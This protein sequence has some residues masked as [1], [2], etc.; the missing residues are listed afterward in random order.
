MTTRC[1]RPGRPVRLPTAQ[2]A[3]VR[4]RMHTTAPGPQTCRGG[5]CHLSSHGEVVLCERHAAALLVGGWA[6]MTATITTLPPHLLVID[7]DLQHLAALQAAG[8]D[9]DETERELWSWSIRCPYSGRD[10]S[11]PCVCWLECDC[12]P[13][14]SGPQR[15]TLDRDGGGPCPDSPTGRHELLCFDGLDGPA[16]PLTSCWLHEDLDVGDVVEDLIT[17]CGLL[18]GEHRVVLGW[19]RDGGTELTLA[20][21][22]GAR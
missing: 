18:P 12:G 15:D 20:S 10:W 2:A 7:V 8:D 9:V 19:G 13:D 16:H 6:P 22:G 1:P 17:R 5:F 21:Q 4:T 14:L 3:A 11:R